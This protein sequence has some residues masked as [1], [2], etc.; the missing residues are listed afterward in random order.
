MISRISRSSVL[1]PGRWK[2]RGNLLRSPGGQEWH[3]M[4][5]IPY[6]LSKLEYGLDGPET[7]A[8]FSRLMEALGG[9]PSHFEAQL[10]LCREAYSADSPKEGSLFPSVGLVTRVFLVEKAQ[11]RLGENSLSQGLVEAGLELRN[12]SIEEFGA[13]R[14]R[15][16][17]LGGDA[18]PS[19]LPDVVWEGAHL[20][21]AEKLLKVVSL[22]DSPHATV[23]GCLQ[24]LLELPQEFV[25]SMRL[26]VPDRA[27][28]KKDLERKRRVSH[29]LASTQGR[30]LADLGSGATLSASEEV[31]VRLIEGQETLLD[32]QA[33][34][35]LRDSTL[36]GLEEQAS[37]LVS[38]ASLNGGLGLFPENVGSLPVLRSHIPG[39]PPLAAR[40]LKFLS[41]NASHLLPLLV[42]RSPVR[43]PAPIT[44]VSRSFERCSLALFSPENLSANSFL[45]GSTGSGKS[46]LVN[47]LIASLKEEEPEAQITIFDVGGSYRKLVGN[48]GGTTLDMSPEQAKRLVNSVLRTQKLGPTIFLKTAIATLC[49]SGDHI[50][51]SHRVAIENILSDCEG[52]VFSIR[53]LE[54]ACVEHPEAAFRDIALW[55][56]PYVAWDDLPVS[57][58]DLEA[59]QGNIRAFDFRLLDGD[60][61]IQRLVLL[62]LVQDIWERLKQSGSPKTLIVFD[63]LWRLLAEARPFLEDMYR[64]IRKKNGAV[65]SV[66][67]NLGDLGEEDFAR[68]VISNSFTRILLQGSGNSALLTRLLDLTPSDLAR[69]M[70]L[71]S[72]KGHY[73]EFWV[74]TPERSQIMRLIASPELYRLAHTE[75]IAV[76]QEKTPE[77]S[78]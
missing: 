71:S 21:A 34:F 54:T 32:V 12:L 78:A 56:R 60:P 11:K 16:L 37:R 3:A 2:E 46:F 30:E 28:M 55:L 41:G 69:I 75:N 8:F 48:L 40:E 17:G 22:T 19:A 66:T 1:F 10:V 74:G 33:C 27:R 58:F 26:R 49:G 24:C 29:A 50:T 15:F 76:M 59:L 62:T 57:R 43:N 61:T 70:S 53:L 73:S 68:V 67:Q 45:C 77:V 20:K 44:V 65:A 4:E 64:T 36:E 25:F 7:D 52:A 14:L 18:D 13:L 39:A 6:R 51:H 47:S 5:V 31:L 72:R 23:P 9:L 38:T 35:V 42:D 63:E